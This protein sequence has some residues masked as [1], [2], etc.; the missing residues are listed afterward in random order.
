MDYSVLQTNKIIVDNNESKKTGDVLRCL[1][2]SGVVSFQEST[3]EEVFLED[4]SQ[5]IFHSEEPVT[6]SVSIFPTTF[7]DSTCRWIRINNTVFV[8]ASVT[9][10]MR[11]GEFQLFS[12]D[13]RLPVKRQSNFENSTLYDT[14]FNGSVVAVFSENGVYQTRFGN[15]FG[16]DGTS[17]IVRVL[18]RN[19]EDEKIISLGNL[20]GNIVLDFMYEINST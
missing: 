7:G 2:N 17:D 4:G 20:I 11:M 1:D 6:S 8:H 16:R 15:A 12:Y 18:I 19:P 10:K 14:Y 3:L 13:F 5:I 9:I